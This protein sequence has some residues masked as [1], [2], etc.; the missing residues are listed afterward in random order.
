MSEARKRK[1]VKSRQQEYGASMAGLRSLLRQTYLGS[2]I[3]EPEASASVI[4]APIAARSNALDPHEQ[5]WKTLAHPSAFLPPPPPGIL[6][7]S[8]QRAPPRLT[9]HHRGLASPPIMRVPVNA[10]SSHCCR[11]TQPACMWRDTRL[12]SR[13]TVNEHGARGGLLEFLAPCV[14]GPSQATK[15]AACRRKQA[16]QYDMAVLCGLLVLPQSVGV[17]D[18]NQQPLEIAVHPHVITRVASLP[19]LCMRS[20]RP[21][22]VRRWCKCERFNGAQNEYG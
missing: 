22:R 5:S 12:V 15:A 20:L 11:A 13:R 7:G 3:S 2:I 14:Y 4:C 16:C 18:R 10:D 6:R 1:N 9:P 8:F 19:A 21:V 17:S